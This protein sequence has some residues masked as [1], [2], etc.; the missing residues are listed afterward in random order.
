MLVSG[1]ETSAALTAEGSL[2]R[3]AVVKSAVAMPHV[4]HSF[5]TFA[6]PWSL[7]PRVVVESIS[8]TQRTLVSAP[9]LATADIDIAS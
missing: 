4:G 9:L 8:R 6:M 7:A 2:S 1:W 3:L 5:L